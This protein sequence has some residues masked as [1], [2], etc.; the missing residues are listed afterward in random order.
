MSSSEGAAQ[1]PHTWLGHGDQFIASVLASL[2][3]DSG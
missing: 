3:E 1:T 2:W